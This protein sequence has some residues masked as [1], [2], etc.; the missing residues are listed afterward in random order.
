MQTYEKDMT[1]EVGADALGEEWKDC[2]V[3][4]SGGN[5]RQGFCV[6][7]GVLTHGYVCPRPCKGHSYYDQG[8]LKKESTNLFQVALWMLILVFSTWLLFI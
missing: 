7:Q 2:V 1:T 5:D 8:R 3:P 4:V 6:K